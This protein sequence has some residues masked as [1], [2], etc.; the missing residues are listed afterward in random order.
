M[1]FVGCVQ[2]WA[3]TSRCV[4]AWQDLRTMVVQIHSC[5]CMCQVPGAGGFAA[6]H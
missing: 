6:L 2:H 5:V 4:V 1:N 3:A